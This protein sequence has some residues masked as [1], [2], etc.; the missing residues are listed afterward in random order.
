MELADSQLLLTPDA[1][2]SR[3]VLV[4]GLPPGGVICTH[5]SRN[6][7][8]RMTSE[9]QLQPKMLLIPLQEQ[10]LLRSIFVDTSGSTYRICLVT[11]LEFFGGSWVI[12]RNPVGQTRG[13]LSQASGGFLVPKGGNA[14]AP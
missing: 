4:K 9:V 3:Q 6:H 1:P 7:A 14:T 10:E 13:F 12:V 11:E 5:S 8:A 2:A